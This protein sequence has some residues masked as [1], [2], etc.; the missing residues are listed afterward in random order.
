[1]LYALDFGPFF[2]KTF[3]SLFMDSM[4]YLSIN[5]INPKDII[6][7]KANLKAFLYKNIT[8]TNDQ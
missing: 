6:F 3:E 2:I 5:K 7:P 1:M 4:V 8:W